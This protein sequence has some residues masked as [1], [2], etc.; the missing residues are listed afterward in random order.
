MVNA[1]LVFMD[2]GERKLINHFVVH[3][4]FRKLRVLRASAVTLHSLLNRHRQAKPVVG[5]MEIRGQGAARRTPA[6][7]HA[8]A[9]RAAAG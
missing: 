9:P 7:R 5:I 3:P 1:S 4:L 2:S 8:V 6:E